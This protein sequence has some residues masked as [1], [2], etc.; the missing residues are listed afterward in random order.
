MTT[1]RGTAQAQSRLAEKLGNVTILERPLHP[2]TLAFA[3]RA[4]LRAR[5]R[6]HRAE[7]YITELHRERSALAASEARYRTLFETIDEG[8]CVIEFTDGPHGA[9]SDYIHIDANPA[10]TRHAGI[11]DIVGKRLREIV[12]ESEASAWASI[13]REVLVTGRPVRFEREL[14]ETGRYLDLAAFRVAGFEERQVAVLFQDVT[15]R[16]R[17]EKALRELNETLESRISEAVAERRLL[18]DVIDHTSLFV[19]IVGN[20]WRLLAINMA[21]EMA[22]HRNFGVR[23]QVGDDIRKLLQN[24]PEQSA[25]LEEVWSRAFKGEEF[26]VVKE[27]SNEGRS[28]EMHFFPLRDPDGHQ[29]GAYQFVSDVTERIA[30]QRKLV[31]LQK[32]TPSANLRWGCARFQQPARSNHFKSR[33]RKEA[34]L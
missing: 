34:Y 14:K 4:A 1:R 33:S 9:L 19:Q 29:I 24:C 16:K 22:F 11:P 20:D 30:E 13:Y 10:Y 3:A 26:T 28:Y 31:E 17:A 5:V 27:L 6:Q 18:A 32:R 2:V 12:S 23:P 7:T 15:A 21:S 8:F 25:A